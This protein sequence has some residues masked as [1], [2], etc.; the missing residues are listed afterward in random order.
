M[1]ASFCSVRFCVKSQFF[2]YPSYKKQLPKAE[3]FPDKLQQGRAW[4]RLNPMTEAATL[5]Q[6]L[7]AH[8]ENLYILSSGTF[9]KKQVPGSISHSLASADTSALRKS[10][11]PVTILIRLLLEHSISINSYHS[12]SWQVGLVSVMLWSILLAQHFLPL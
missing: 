3:V 12:T 7:P 9:S 1:E 10:C 5:I 8:L 11:F 2:Y 4:V 6:R